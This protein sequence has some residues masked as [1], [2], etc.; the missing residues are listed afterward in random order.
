MNRIIDRDSEKDRQRKKGRDGKWR[1]TVVR[2]MRAIAFEG[3]TMERTNMLI[4]DLRRGSSEV[5]NHI[6]NN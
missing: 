3:Q 6:W 1:A 2:K 5:I 4:D